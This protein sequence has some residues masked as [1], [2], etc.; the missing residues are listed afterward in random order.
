MVVLK[1]RVSVISYLNNENK[2]VFS[3]SQDRNIEQI[4]SRNPVN[5]VISSG[6][7]HR[8]LD[9]TDLSVTWDIPVIVKQIEVEHGCFNV[10]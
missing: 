10:L 9:N 5:V 8:I 1:L 4:L 6:G 3:V 2:C 7:L